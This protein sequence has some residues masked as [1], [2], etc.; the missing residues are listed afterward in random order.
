MISGIE[1][2]TRYITKL[3]P[4]LMKDFQDWVLL[5]GMRFQDNRLWW[6]NQKKRSSPHEGVDFYQYRTC[7]GEIRQISPKLCIPALLDGEV[8]KIQKDFLGYS[9]YMRHTTQLKENVTLYS[10]LSHIRSASLLY[11]GLNVRAGEIIGYLDIVFKDS[12]VPMH[13]H[14]SLAWVQNR[15]SPEALSWK[16]LNNPDLVTFINP[17]SPLFR[18]PFL[19]YSA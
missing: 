17:L 13:L 8:I 14:L 15:V 10:I 7:S 3:K 19:N 1:L 4:D 16:L 5:P 11:P 18:N 2:L 6:G 12:L 9:V